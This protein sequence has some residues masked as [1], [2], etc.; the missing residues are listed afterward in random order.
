MVESARYDADAKVIVI[1]FNT[2]AGKTPISVDVAAMV[3]E[4]TAGTGLTSDGS[5]FSVN[6]AEVT[7]VST[8]E[9]TINEL[10]TA[11]AETYYTLRAA[12][13]LSARVDTI[14]GNGE[15]SIA[16]A[17]SDA[18]DYADEKAGDVQT[19]LNNTN[20]TLAVVSGDYLKTSDKNELTTS[21]AAK[22]DLTALAATNAALAVVSGD[23]LKTSDKTTLTTAIGL[24]LDA[25]AIEGK[26]ALS[27]Q[28]EIEA[29]LGLG[30]LAKK[31]TVGTA[32]L[33]DGLSTAIA[34]KAES[35][36]LAATDAKVGG[37]L[38]DYLKASDKTTLMT[39]IG[40][41]LDHTAIAGKVALSSQVE[42]EMSLRLGSLA[43]KSSVSNADV[44]D[45][46]I[47]A[48]KLGDTLSSEIAGKASAS[49]LAATNSAVAAISADYVNTA[50]GN[51]LSAAAVSAVKAQ[52]K[53]KLSAVTLTADLDTVLSAINALYTW[54]NS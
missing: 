24:K 9:S 27:S 38:S 39:E 11:A 8:F 45:K 35:S 40:K 46:A 3:H 36:A 49:S 16:K 21:I 32:D 42:I 50:E 7:M 25:S 17:L 2:D 44:A 23:Y 53:S 26:V 48:A 22:A 5:I 14:Q 30:D 54:A 19:N 37:I 43:K 52:L 15:G 33:D 51:A 31:S 13:D 18:K 29:S 12:K 10:Y 47:T 4:Y 1:S 6:P 28:T 34:A 41:K 20:A